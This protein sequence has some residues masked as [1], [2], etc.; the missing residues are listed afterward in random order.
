[1]QALSL[2]SQIKD[3]LKTTYGVNA[4]LRHDEFKAFIVEYLKE[5]KIDVDELG[6][7]KKKK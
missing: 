4:F 1:M 5:L 2:R 3:Y 6:A 7:Y